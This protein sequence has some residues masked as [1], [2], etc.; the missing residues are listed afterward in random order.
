MI[1]LEDGKKYRLRNGLTTTVKKN[2]NNGTGYIFEG[3]IKEPQHKTP[4]HAS[5]LRNG[6]L[7]H[8]NIKHP[9]DILEEL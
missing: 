5:W 3:L 7:V 1:I 6:V 8:L 2:K 4:T 9:L